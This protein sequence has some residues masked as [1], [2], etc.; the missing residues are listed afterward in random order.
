AAG[1]FVLDGFPRTVNQAV[2]LDKSLAK[3]GQKIDA[4]LNL[5]VDDQS[6]AKRLTGR[7][8]CPKC[9]EVYHIENLKPKV[10][11][12][13]D[14]DGSEL[15]QRPDD[16]PEVVLNRL[17]TYH[18]LTEPVVDYYNSNNTVYNVNADRDIDEITSDIFEKFSQ[19]VS[20]R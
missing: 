6:V 18:K 8:S 3:S 2:E 1:G 7:R 4:V 15:T 13:C 5:E 16:K 19:L 11:G 12:K 17:E 14:K 20:A 9:G 10:D